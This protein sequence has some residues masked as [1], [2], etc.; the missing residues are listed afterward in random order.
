M[1]GK[2]KLSLKQMERMQTKKDEE[3][4]QTEKKAAGEFKKEKKSLNIA[5]PDP[6]N[7]KIVSEVKKMKVLTPFSVAS[8][9]DVRISVAK[10]FL[11][12]LEKLGVVTLVSQSRN[13][14]VYSV[15]A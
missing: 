15:A 7:E 12:E 10:D 4:P 3:K 14:R 9:F 8:R 11:E 1:G 6:R 5:M 13:T 2:K